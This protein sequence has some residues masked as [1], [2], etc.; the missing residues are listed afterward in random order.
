MSENLNWCYEQK[1][2]KTVKS[3]Q[4]NGFEAA[5]CTDKEKAYGKILEEARNANS[6]GLAGSMTL[7]ELQLMPELMTMGKELLRRDLPGLTPN[8]QDAIRRRQLT[9]DLF[10]T[11]TNAVTLAGQLVNVDGIG[12]RVGAMTFGPNKVLVV[13][14]RN[15]ITEDLHA[16]LKRI[17]SIAAPANARRLNKSLPCAITGFCTDCDSPERICR[18][19][20]ILDRMP[21]LSNIKVLIVN[22]DMGY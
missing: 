6:I 18:A 2:L 12:N 20:V 17:K 5:Y 10:L 13:A 16:A 22:A 4:R 8:E 3:L 1:C 7:E 19:T 21:S 15:K 14:G 11:S 9:C